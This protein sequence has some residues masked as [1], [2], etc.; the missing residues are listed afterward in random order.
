M[1]Q[2]QKKYVILGS[3]CALVLTLAVGY[4]AFQAVL[5][6]NGT[7]NISS[8]W[9]VEITNI[10]L[11]ANKGATNAEEPTYDNTNG[12]SAT[13]NTNLE[14]PGDY[15]TYKIEVTNKGSLDATFADM[16][17][18]ESTNNDIIFYLNKNQNNEEIAG[19]LTKNSTLTKASGSSN[20]GYVYV[21]ALYRDY[22]GQQSPTGDN[23]TASMTVTFDFEQKTSGGS[24][25]GPSGEIT[26]DYTGILYSKN[27]LTGSDYTSEN[28]INP[29]DA[30]D[31]IKGYAK[32]DA[33]TLGNFYLK[34]MMTNG[35]VESTVVCFVTDAEHCIQ[36]GDTS[37]YETNKS[38]LESQ[39][40]WFITNYG[41]CNYR[42]SS[43]TCSID[44]FSVTISS[45]GR[46]YSFDD[47]FNCV[48][49]PGGSAECHEI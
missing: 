30:V 1:N 37:Y 3:L 17:M 35:Q 29:G 25:I 8:D 19:A 5:K 26:S 16:T 43:S 45:N 36:G 11:Y 46:V 28:Y 6:I 27:I 44:L 23:K 49:Q 7:T 21:T 10:E 41:S 34:H 31:K 40:Q 48:V 2:V 18:P 42:T 20:V 22:E 39:E 38:V 9:K 13:F 14:S 15:A 12:L 33:S 4:A 32:E 24:V 47:K